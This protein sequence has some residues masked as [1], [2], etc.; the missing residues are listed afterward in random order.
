M[1]VRTKTEDA[2]LFYPSSLPRAS[3]RL[4]NRYVWMNRDVI[5][6]L[7]GGDVYV[8]T[9]ERVEKPLEHQV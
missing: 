4:G 1:I 8:P 6:S 9:F 2:V 7:K 3:F 5:G